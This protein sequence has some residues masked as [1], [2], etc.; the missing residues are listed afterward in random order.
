M[1]VQHP[2]PASGYMGRKVRDRMRMVSRRFDTEWTDDEVDERI[3]LVLADG[4]A[5]DAKQAGQPDA[6]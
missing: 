1:P 2:V 4:N 6:G 3:E 5:C